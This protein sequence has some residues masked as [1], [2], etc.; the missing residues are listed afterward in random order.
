MQNG[1]LY[2]DRT[3]TVLVTLDGDAGDINGELCSTKMVLQ[4]AQH[5]NQW[6]V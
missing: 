2:S 6:T 3:I 1:Q 5:V 4:Y